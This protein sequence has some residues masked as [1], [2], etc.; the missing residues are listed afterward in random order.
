MTPPFENLLGRGDLV[1]ERERL[2]RD[3]RLSRSRARRGAGGRAAGPRGAVSSDLEA[4]APW[5]LLRRGG[6]SKPT[7]STH[8]TD[9]PQERAQS[10]IDVLRCPICNAETAA[11]QRVAPPGG[12]WAKSGASSAPEPVLP[13]RRDFFLRVETHCPSLFKHVKSQ[14]N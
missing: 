3:R 10:Q 11:F 2:S 6:R 13:S 14:S 12:A 8:R 9:D 7:T 1:A 4:A 5:R